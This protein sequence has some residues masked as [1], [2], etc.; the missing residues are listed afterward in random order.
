M[1]T[2]VI[3]LTSDPNQTFKAKVPIGGD[4]VSLTYEVSYNE[5]AGCWLMAILKDGAPLLASLP[6]IPGDWP[7]ENIL[8]QYEYLGIGGAYIVPASQSPQE[9][10]PGADT[11][12]GGW[13]L[14][15]SDEGR[16]GA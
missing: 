11:L 15:W 10:W 7:A 8:G 6:L 1:A 4:N 9:E 13:L 14:V 16:E 3:P 2:V 5:V 12:G